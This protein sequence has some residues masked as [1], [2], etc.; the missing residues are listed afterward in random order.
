MLAYKESKEPALSGAK[1]RRACPE[2]SEEPA[3][4]RE[5]RSP[6]PAKGKG[7]AL[8]VAEGTETSR[9]LRDPRRRFALPFFL[10]LLCAAVGALAILSSVHIARADTLCVKPGG[11]GGCYASINTAITTAN[12]SDT[13]RVAMGVYTENVLI[14]K[15]VTL[16]G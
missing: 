8:S 1:G 10:G 11:G 9:A 14:T 2:Q 13:I 4:S 6:E 16:E 15:T 7:P 3:L 12:I 5:S